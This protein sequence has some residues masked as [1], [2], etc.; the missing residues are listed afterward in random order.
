MVFSRHWVTNNIFR[1]SKLS[2]NEVYNKGIISSTY[3]LVRA[4]THHL[5][6]ILKDT[7]S[8][9]RQCGFVAT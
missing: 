5:H 2:L 1:D 6:I 8:Y 3:N 4:Q 9:N 7:S